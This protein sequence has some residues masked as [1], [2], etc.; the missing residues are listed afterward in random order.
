[1]NVNELS[2]RVERLELENRMMKRAGVAVVGV[3][4]V[5]YARGSVPGGC[6]SLES[7]PLQGLGVRIAL[8]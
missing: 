1:M 3:A 2:G 5:R 8:P 7:L 6:C 4:L